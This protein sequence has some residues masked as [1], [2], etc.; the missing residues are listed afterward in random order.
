MDRLA[1]RLIE[2]A[3]LAFAAVGQDDGAYGG[4]VIAWLVH[5]IHAGMVAPNCGGESKGKAPA[6]AI[7]WADWYAESSGKSGRPRN[8][9]LNEN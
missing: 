9:K 8:Q 3:G 6:Y 2:L 5:A 4:E 7:M 1:C